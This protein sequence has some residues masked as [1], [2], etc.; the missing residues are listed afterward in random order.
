[1]EIAADRNFDPTRYPDIVCRATAANYY[2]RRGLFFETDDEA[3]EGARRF[4]RE[5][6]PT[7]REHLYFYFRMPPGHESRELF[8]RLPGELDGHSKAKWTATASNDERGWYF[9]EFGYVPLS[10]ES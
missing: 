2:R 6:E 4:A 10:E 8:A 3:I 1:E 7:D 5:R 9:I